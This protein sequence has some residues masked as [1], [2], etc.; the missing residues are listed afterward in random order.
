MG[1]EPASVGPSTLS[2]INISETSL[3]IAI[4]FYLKHHWGGGTAALGFGVYQFRTLV[5]MVNDDIYNILDEFEIRPDPTT[6]YVVSY[7]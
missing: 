2:N 5:S 7:H 6:D 3:S 1:V 4:K